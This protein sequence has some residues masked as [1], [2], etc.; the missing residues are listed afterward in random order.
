[1]AVQWSTFPI[2]F[3]GGLLSNLSPLQHGINGVGSATILQNFEPNKEGGYSKI[4]GYT[5]FSDTEVPGSGEVLC[6]KAINSGKVLAS[7]KNASNNTE[8]YYNTG[9]STWT[10]AGSSAQSNAG[11]ALYAEYNFD[12]TDKIVFVDG[13]NYPGIYD[14][15][16]NTITF[17]TSSDSSDVEAV[18]NVAIFKNT[19]FYAKDN[20]VYFTAPLTVDD[21]SAANGA[22]TINVGSDITGLVVFRDQ[23]IIFTTDTIKRLTGNTAADFQLSPVTDRIGCI[24]AFSIQEFGGDVMYLAPDGLRLLSATDRIG[25]FALD[26]VSD[27]IKKDSTD[28]LNYSPTFA[29][30]IIRGKSQYRIFSYS[31]SEQ[32]ATASGL[33][34][35]KYVAQGGTGV[36]W[37]TTKGIKVFVADS[38]YESGEETILFANNT[39]Y[40]YIMDYNYAFKEPSVDGEPIQAIFETP[41]MP[42]SDPQLRKSFYKSTLYVNPLGTIDMKMY[43]KYDFDTSSG[44]VVQPPVIPIG[45]SAVYG[46][47]GG[48]STNTP[49]N[50]WGASDSIWGEAYLGGSLESIYQTNLVGSG[51]TIAIRLEDNTTNPS[52][53]LD[54]LVLEYR[55]HDRQ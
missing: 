46:S 22:G 3:Q 13:T 25:D 11:R 2:E 45:T 4:R 43:V 9:G 30:C 32:T 14:D 44:S 50:L 17:L 18:S 27:T 39:G 38:I 47:G 42:I 16:T 33:I 40:V 15:S 5:P 49:V 55:Q 7:R 34:A 12:G 20:I 51:K 53:T 52:F 35:T 8:Y 36:V 26:V 28:F 10:S 54:T 24:D 6:V 19:A 1:M 29:S 41:Y 48:S 37:S 31:A 23:L 21:F